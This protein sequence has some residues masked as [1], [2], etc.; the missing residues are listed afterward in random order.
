LYRFN[1]SLPFSGQT[2]GSITIDTGQQG[3][4]IHS[5]LRKLLPV[6]ASNTV[7]S[8]N[9]F[10]RRAGSRFLLYLSSIDWSFRRQRQQHLCEALSE[11]YDDILFVGP[12]AIDCAVQEPPLAFS[13]TQR[14]W[15]PVVGGAPNLGLAGAA[16]NDTQARLIA[17][18]LTR[19]LPEDYDILCAFPA[20][21]P[22]LRHLNPQKLVYD[23]IDDYSS[24]PGLRGSLV[25]EEQE[26]LQEADLVLATHP[27][28]LPSASSKQT[29][30]LPNGA[31][32][33]I[34]QWVEQD[35]EREP[36]VV[37]LGA[38]EEWFDWHLL[39]CTANI[40][41]K[42]T[43]L[44][45]GRAAEQPPDLL[46]PN[47]VLV[48]EMPHEQAIEMLRK[49]SIGIIPFVNSD[50][51]RTINP[52]KA[53]EYLA[54]GLPVVSSSFL[55]RSGID[56]DGIHIADNAQEFAPIIEGLHED[57]TTRD[58]QALRKKARDNTWSRRSELL[59]DNLDN[60]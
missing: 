9:M 29:L 28:L 31:P 45:I 41:K 13:V 2:G 58:R 46:P 21:A 39:L 32:D 30:L 3:G 47:V 10:R 25:M 49:S 52:V 35:E 22:V 8:A 51:T 53:Y 27:S 55:L 59:I 40:L 42:F 4:Q 26:L 50:F 17:E 44:I 15:S 56:C 60:L 36:T 19:F 6:P 5:V 54:A 43:F 23:R 24:F 18:K 48:G 12:A 33:V 20:W 1:V 57:M 7:I 38:V 14:V 11:R 34:C 37:Y 16:L